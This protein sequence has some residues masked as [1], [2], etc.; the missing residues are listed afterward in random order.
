MSW[1]LC[2]SY[3]DVVAA[4]AA[5][6]STR[7]EAVLWLPGQER[8]SVSAVPMDPSSLSAST[9]PTPGISEQC[10]QC[11]QRDNWRHEQDEEQHS[12]NVN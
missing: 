3:G 9:L 6:A 2:G 8:K 12:R 10:I 4:A 7:R 11:G 1:L 5:P